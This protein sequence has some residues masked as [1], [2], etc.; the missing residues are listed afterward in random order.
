M[1]ITRRWVGTKNCFSHFLIYWSFARRHWRNQ[2]KC[3][4]RIQSSIAK[5]HWY[6]SRDCPEKVS[7]FFDKI[8]VQ[9]NQ[10]TSVF[11][12][13][14]S[15]KCVAKINRNFWKIFRPFLILRTK[16]P[17]CKITFKKHTLKNCKSLSERQF[18]VLSSNTLEIGKGKSSLGVLVIYK[19]S[20]CPTLNPAFRLLNVRVVTSSFPFLILI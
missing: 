5:L 8:I 14:L 15:I 9:T 6:L 18:S 17:T 20:K 12:M 1:R 13:L 4:T 7:F 19:P 10:L 2:V 11:I 16:A 3:Y